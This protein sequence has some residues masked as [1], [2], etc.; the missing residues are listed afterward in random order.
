[1]DSNKEM[2]SFSPNELTILQK[3]WYN[4]TR[5]QSNVFGTNLFLRLF[6][7]HSNYLP[8]FGFPTTTCLKDETFRGCA[9]LAAHGANVMYALNMVF[10]N[11]DDLEMVDELLSKLVHSHVRRGIEP[12]M[13]DDIVQPFADVMDGIRSQFDLNEVEIIERAFMFVKQRIQQ[14][15]EEVDAADLFDDDSSHSSIDATII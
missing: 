15:Y 4:I 1:M 12:Q 11:L 10:D 3:V 5:T 9:K 13:F 7:L 2:S 8:M 14:L 6:E